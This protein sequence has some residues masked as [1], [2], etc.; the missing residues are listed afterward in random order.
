[1]RKP[2][3]LLLAVALLPAYAEDLTTTDGKTYTGVTVTKVDPDGLRIAHSSG[4]AKVPFEKLSDE[5][6]K[7]HGY[8]PFNAYDHA[9]AEKAKQAAMEKA[10]AERA[11]AVQAQ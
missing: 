9:Q 5:I 10:E 8:D 4:T 3:Y 1:M 2:A 11:R 7:K 6:Q